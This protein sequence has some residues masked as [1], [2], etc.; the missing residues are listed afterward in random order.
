MRGPIAVATT[1]DTTMSVSSTQRTAAFLT[2]ALSVYLDLVRFLAAFAVLVAHMDQD[3]LAAGWLPLSSLSHEAVVVFFVISG[4]VIAT[5][6]QRRERDWRTYTIARVVRIY[7]VVIPAIAL[8]FAVAAIGFALDPELWLGEAGA[9]FSVLDGLSS[10]L[11]LNESWSLDRSLPWNDP[12]WSLCYEAWYYV[13]FG[14]VC[15]APMRSRVLWIGLCALIA[16]PAVL[17]LMPVWLLGAWLA[18]LQRVP[19]WSTTRA[20]AIVV[21]SWA[22]VWAISASGVDVA[23]RGW[24]NRNVPSYW[25]LESSQR[26]IT[27]YALAALVAWNFVAFRALPETATAWLVRMARPIRFAAGFTFSL[28]LFHRPLTQFFGHFCAEWTDSSMGVVSILAVI[29]ALCMLLGHVTESKKYVLRGWVERSLL[30]SPA[31]DPDAT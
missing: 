10:L 20:V 12:F 27:D 18:R 26:L 11:F 9:N 19:A 14:I 15:F 30:R 1:T 2:P 7:S 21:A 16:G 25:R 24:L 4:L 6:V 23:L 31:V 28:Y 8:S 22:I 17:A 5:T 3:G 29:I 13:I